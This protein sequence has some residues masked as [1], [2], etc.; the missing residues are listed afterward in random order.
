L[1]LVVLYLLVAAPSALVL[2]AG[3]RLG[4]R[5][6]ESGRQEPEAPLGSLV[7]AL[8]ALL[9]FL[10]G[11]SFNAGAGRLD[12]RRQLVIAEAGAL[13]TAYLRAEL[14][15]Q[16]QGDQIRTLL[17]EYAD[18]RLQTSDPDRIE[19]ALARSEEI[20]REV[21]ARLA[22]TALVERSVLVSAAAQA[23]TTVIELHNKRS[24]VVYEHRIPI[25]IWSTLAGVMALS[26]ISVGY[27]MGLVGRRWITVALPFLLSVCLVLV[28][29]ADLDRVDQRVL[30]VDQ[31]A[32]VEA[33][34]AMR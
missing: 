3:L 26:M 7:G 6:R 32:M 16:P 20:H 18:V 5:S 9:A 27:Y 17:R 24:T 33:L 8:L 14:L 4:R 30:S 13:V 2:W 11:F 19:A 31:R 28:L 34:D 1:P 15:P 29:I 23:L 25:S 22:E 10:L 21:W 12:A